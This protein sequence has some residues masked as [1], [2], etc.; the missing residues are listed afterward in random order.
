MAAVL[1]VFL[2]IFGVTAA[3]SLLFAL[4]TGIYLAPYEYSLGMHIASNKLPKDFRQIRSPGEEIKRA[5][6]FYSDLLHHRKP[7]FD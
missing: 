1:M 6:K 3:V 7:T 5:T 2:F 4:L